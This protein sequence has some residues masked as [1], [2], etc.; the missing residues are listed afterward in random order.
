MYAKKT[1]ISDDKE[2]RPGVYFHGLHQSKGSADATLI[3]QW[4]CSPVYVE[5]TTSNDGADFGRLLHFI[6][7]L[8]HWHYWAMPMHLLKGSGEDMRG[9]LQNMG[10][11]IDPSS[12]KSLN[13]YLQSQHPK[14]KVIAA[15]A[16]GWQSPELFIMPQRNIGKGDA[17]YQNETARL[18]DF[19]QTGTL[20]GW[21]DGIGAHC[22]G[23]SLL[24]LG[25][26]AALAG[27]LLYHLKR[28]GG[29][30][31]IV[32]DSSIGKTAV[33][34]AS[35]SVWGHGE[36]F[37]RTWRATSN[38]LEG[39]ASL[40]NDT[41][42]ALDEMGEADPREIGAVVYEIANGAGKTRA[43]RSGAARSH[44]RWRVMLLSSGEVGLSDYMTEGGKR[45][46]A[47]QEIRLLDI[48]AHRFFGAWD[49]LH[50]LPSGQQFTD[51]LLRT[52]TT[53]YGHAG[54]A[55]IECLLKSG[56]TDDLPAALEMLCKQY[57]TCTG[58]ENRAAERFA[59]LALAGELAITWG[60]LPATEGA[61]RDAMLALFD[62]WRSN[63]GEGP[64]EDVKICTNL[65]NFISQH[66]ES[67][68]VEYKGPQTKFI[69][70]L[71]IRDR[72]GWWKSD[73]RA[74]AIS[75]YAGSS[76]NTSDSTI[77]H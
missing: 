60:L 62:A 18:D 4:I 3:D 56:E 13:H 25:V 61:A 63:R 2:L 9:E 28:Q 12:F 45:S 68:F 51:A 38:G 32:G 8:G 1:R 40:H 14:R 47:G 44:R 74:V 31:H 10:V 48:P 23:N 64:G 7:T 16:T 33:V 70:D 15:T 34:Q 50:E 43:N 71:T 49:D 77:G 69:G 41:L 6:D 52:S 19:R 72:A 75:A 30:F 55:F 36:Q 39:V 27:P 59:I 20:E 24:M 5:A 58:Q 57:P 21:K 66:G 54:P 17:I 76:H 22:T 67:M 37:M 46:R 29:G 65:R 26:C 35:A 73:Q 53:H 42:L 11:E